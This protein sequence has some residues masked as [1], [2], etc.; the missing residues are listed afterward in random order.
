M[1]GHGSYIIILTIS[2]EFKIITT[3]EYERNITVN[4][5]SSLL[6]HSGILTR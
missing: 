2:I 6:L 5:S 1:N 4:Y 3:S